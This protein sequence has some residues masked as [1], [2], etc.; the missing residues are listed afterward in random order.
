VA[1]AAASS[2]SRSKTAQSAGSKRRG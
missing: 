2:K 1:K